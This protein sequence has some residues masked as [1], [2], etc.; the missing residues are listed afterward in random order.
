MVLWYGKI[1]KGLRS[2]WA[3]GNVDQFL[4]QEHFL[5]SK[6]DKPKINGIRTGIHRAWNSSTLGFSG[7][8]VG[9]KKVPGCG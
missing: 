4:T 3:I 6:Q 8:L 2:S 5:V 7:S 9:K 1:S